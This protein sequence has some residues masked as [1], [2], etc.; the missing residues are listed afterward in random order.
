MGNSQIK[1][2]KREENKNRERLCERDQ[3]GEEKVREGIKQKVGRQIEVERER[4][5]DRQ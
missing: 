2:G 5:I 4:L 1:M 3:R